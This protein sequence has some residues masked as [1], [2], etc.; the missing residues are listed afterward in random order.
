MKILR[1]LRQ[2]DQDPELLAEAENEAGTSTR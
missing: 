1:R 2:G